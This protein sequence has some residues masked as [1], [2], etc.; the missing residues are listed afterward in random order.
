MD[1]AC[2]LLGQPYFLFDAQEASK[3]SATTATTGTIRRRVENACIYVFTYLKTE[4]LCYFCKVKH[5]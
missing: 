2:I 3:T 4:N 5:F 1:E